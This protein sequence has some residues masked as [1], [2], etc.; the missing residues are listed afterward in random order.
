MTPT[1]NGYQYQLDNFDDTNQSQEI[2]FIYK[3]P[4]GETLV[5]GTTNEE[6]IRALIHRINHLQTKLPCRE[7]AMA[8]MKLEEALLWLGKRTADRKE[9]N[10]EGTNQD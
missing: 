7:N 6:V 4:N 3:N 1:I 5:D 8:I 10:V 2:T 9:R